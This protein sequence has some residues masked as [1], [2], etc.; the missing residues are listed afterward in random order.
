MIKTRNLLLTAA[1]GVAGLIAI[2]ASAQYNPRSGGWDGSNRGNWGWQDNDRDHDRDHDHDHHGNNGYGNHG[3]GNY[4]RD[5][6]NKAYQ[7][8]YKDGI[9]DRQH[10]PQRRSRNWSH[11]YDAQA[12]QNGYNAAY[13]GNSGYYGNGGYGNGGY[14]GNGRYGNSGAYGQYGGRGNY[15][16]QGYIDGVNDGTNDRRTGHSYRPTQHPGWDHPDRGYNSSMGISKQQYEQ[17]YRNAYMQ[18][19]Q[20]GYNGRR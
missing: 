8:G 1:L 11:D 18:G 15:A 16:Q 2:P 13:R 20:R 9:W 19:Y 7:Q 3:Y 17:E 14:Y 12:Y 5:S 4:S 10:G 6:Q